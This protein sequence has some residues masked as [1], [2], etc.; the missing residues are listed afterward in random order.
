MRET[1]RG[2]ESGLTHFY[3]KPTLLLI[4]AAVLL[5]LPGSAAPV[6]AGPALPFPQHVAYGPGILLPDQWTAAQRDDDVRAF[7]DEWKRR[8]L[9]EAGQGKE[10]EPMFRITFGSK[11]PDVTVSEGQGY[12]M[13]IVALMAGHEPQAQEIFDG[14][15][16]FALAKPSRLDRRLMSWRLPAKSG[17]SS[18]FDGDA[19][20]AYS[21]LLAHAQ[22]GK[23]RP[24]YAAAAK[25]R[26]AGIMEATIGSRTHLPLLGDWVQQD[27]KKYNQTTPRSS[28]FMPG[29]FRA[30]ARFTADPS[31]TSVTTESERVIDSFQ[32]GISKDTGLVPDFIIQADKLPAPA[33]AG[34]LEAKTDGAF[35]YNAGRL[36]WR[37]GADALFRPAGSAAAQA[38][39]ISAWARG[40]TQGD[41]QKIRAGYQLDGT[42]L[43]GRDYFTSFF[44]APLGV[45]AMTDPQGQQWLNR[46]YRSIRVTH[47]DYFEDSVALQ[48]LIIMS[49]NYWEP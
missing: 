29:H 10:G 27:G 49:G 4:A 46:I 7:Y 26:L 13:V 35:A 31:W 5:P 24:D 19:D 9:R 48:C 39:K 22:W 45:A 33:T 23:A 47:E 41:P 6:Q 8:Y 36:P 1:A 37:L 18:A 16:A 34:F 2:S 17:T 11:E 3:M 44:A 28:D 32:R 40:T 25:V 20:I 43:E 42:P 21:L 14:L 12:G 30:F 15:H 38:A